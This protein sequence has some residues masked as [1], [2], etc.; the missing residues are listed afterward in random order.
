MPQRCWRSERAALRAAEVVLFGGSVTANIGAAPPL[1][2]DP[3]LG[4]QNGGFG[5]GLLTGDIGI[6]AP[7]NGEISITITD[8]G[9]A[10]NTHAGSVYQVFGLDVTPGGGVG[11]N[12]T[13]NILYAAVGT[14]PT[15]FQHPHCFPDMDITP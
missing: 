6:L 4:N 1:G 8:L 12:G 13:D 11:P 15:G 5:G 3:N 2:I 7:F 9:T 14:A 10:V